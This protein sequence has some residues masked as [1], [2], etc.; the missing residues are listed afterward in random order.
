M[1]GVKRVE[2]SA[3][4]ELAKEKERA[5]KL[6]AYQH[7]M[8][9][10]FEKR[11]TGDLDVELLRFTAQVL[12]ANPDI[13]TLWNIRREV[14]LHLKKKEET[15]FSDLVTNDLRLV[16]TCLRSNPKSYGAWHHRYWLMKETNFERVPEEIKLCTKYLTFDER[17]FHCW[18]Y[19]RYLLENSASVSLEDELKFTT[20]KI[21]SNFSN[22]S[23][24]HLR[25]TLL[26]RLSQDFVPDELQLIKNAAFTDPNDQ[27]VWL[28][29]R[30][31]LM[32][33]IAHGKSSENEGMLQGELEWVKELND[34]EQDNKWII[35]TLIL[36]MRLIDF[37]KF[38]P[39]IDVCI[40]K[41]IQLDP[42]RLKYYKDLR[43]KYMTEWELGQLSLDLKDDL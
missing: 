5:K 15:N 27:S 40:N 38:S 28:Y 22:Y 20:D 30:W 37:K 43:A 19:R 16:E 1:H 39:E 24:W 3:E 35:S 21:V 32:S 34:L 12:S 10:I 7:M 6:K 26:P 9:I 8:K 42:K 2:R 41:I 4:E 29:H 31:L 36:L 33:H 11:A 13:S 17:N 23:S 25:S 14:L 18:D